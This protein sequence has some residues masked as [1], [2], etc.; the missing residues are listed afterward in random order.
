MS[1][2]AILSQDAKIEFADAIVENL[3]QVSHVRPSFLGIAVAKLILAAPPL[4]SPIL[5]LLTAA[6]ASGKTCGAAIPVI[7]TSS[8]PSNAAT[9]IRAAFK[10]R[11]KRACL[12]T[13]S[14]S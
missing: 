1:A 13:I 8:E 5:P 9:T 3:I 11:V 4:E 12:V 14:K 7:G 10:R 2:L 6:A